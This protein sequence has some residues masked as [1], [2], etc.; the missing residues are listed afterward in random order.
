MPTRALTTDA[1]G[2]DPSSPVPGSDT[3]AHISTG[4]VSNGGRSDRQIDCKYVQGVVVGRP[5]IRAGNDGVT[6]ARFQLRRGLRR[7]GNDFAPDPS[8]EV[9]TVLTKGD[10]ADSLKTNGREGLYLQVSGYCRDPEWAPNEIT[11][12]DRMGILTG[13]GDVQTINPGAYLGTGMGRSSGDVGMAA[14]I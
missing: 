12:F 11:A 1:S 9:V 13:L 5:E 2:I 4:P 7:D 10:Q 3:E 14:G 6:H 8:G